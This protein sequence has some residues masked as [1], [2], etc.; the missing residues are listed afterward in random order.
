MRPAGETRSPGQ[1][2]VDRLGRASTMNHVLDRLPSWVVRVGFQA[3]V[4][5]LQLMWFF[6]RPRSAGVRCV[7]R[8]EGSVLLVRHTYGD[9]DWML[10]GGRVQHG[11]DPADTARR[12]M[13]EELR[14]RAS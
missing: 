10:P 2:D 6:T 3:A 7:L 14:V 5:L 11:E 8:H 12:E 1:R 13:A 4:P 9:R